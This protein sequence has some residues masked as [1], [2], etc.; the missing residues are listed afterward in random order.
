MEREKF[1]SRLK[2]FFKENAGH[3]HIDMAFLYGSY[4]CGSPHED[5]DIDLGVVFLPEVKSRGMT[6]SLITDLTYEI[7]KALREE[8]YLVTKQKFF[9][10]VDIISLEKDFR[11]PM[12]YY[13]VIIFGKPVFIKDQ[14]RFIDLKLEAISQM[15]DFSIFGIA[16][17]KE[18][19]QKNI[20]EV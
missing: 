1:I 17:Q 11:Q 15:E 8:A 10:G 6:F 13:N 12:L 20:K 7:V 5:S 9:N 2:D 19:A 4:A 3:Y 18:I 16:W 14:N